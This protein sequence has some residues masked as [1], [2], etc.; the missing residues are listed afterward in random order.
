MRNRGG[1]VKA[2]NAGACIVIAAGDCKAGQHA[3][4]VF[5]ALECDSRPIVATVNHGRG[6]IAELIG[7]IGIIRPFACDCNVLA[8]EVNVFEICSRQHD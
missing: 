2:A 5:A 6:D 3:V 1:T 4:G 8:P 7:I